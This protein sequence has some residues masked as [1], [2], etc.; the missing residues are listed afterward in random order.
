[1]TA[2]DSVKAEQ[3]S[4]GEKYRTSREIQDKIVGAWMD[5]VDLLSQLG[6]GLVCVCGPWV[7]SK[8]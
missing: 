5:G 1:M 4:D 6:F 3:N 7:T 2:K 8:S